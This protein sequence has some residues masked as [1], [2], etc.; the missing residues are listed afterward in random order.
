[1][2][3]VSGER[4]VR[5]GRARR[6]RARRQAGRPGLFSVALLCVVAACGAGAVAGPVPDGAWG[7]PQGNLTVYPDSATLDLPCA[8]GRIQQAIVAGADG[9]FDLPG[10]Y[11]I[12]AG[13]VQ[14][15]GPVWQPARFQGSRAGDEIT[16]I[17]VLSD[18]LTV[19]PLQFHR[20]TVGTF[21]RCV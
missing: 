10:L 6:A 9:T 8:A 3:Q 14:P 18:S 1:M 2:L 5:G 19:G 15:G 20:G 17:I 16:L 4:A 21:P 7:G 11:A 12:Q 13:P